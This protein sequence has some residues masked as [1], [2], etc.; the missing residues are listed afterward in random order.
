[1]SLEPNNPNHV[2]ISTNV[3]PNTGIA[4]DMPHQIFR[5]NIQLNDETDTINWEQLTNDPHNE[6]LRPMIV[7]RKNYN[8]I[9]W[10]QG[11]LNTYTYYYLDAVGVSF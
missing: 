9:L 5:A 4:L 8:V 3:D 2:V 7:N 6:N 10:L 1:M 11:Q